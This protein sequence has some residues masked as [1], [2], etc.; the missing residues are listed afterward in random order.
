VLSGCGERHLPQSRAEPS[1]PRRCCH[2]GVVILCRCLS[3][4]SS[5]STPP[6]H[7]APLLPGLRAR[8]GRGRTRAHV[9]PQRVRLR[10]DL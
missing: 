6:L 10:S 2:R 9:L 3:P 1:P 5:L 4:F 8:A 7:L